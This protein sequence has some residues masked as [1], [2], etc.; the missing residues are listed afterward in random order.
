MDRSTLS[1]S[2]RSGAIAASVALLLACGGSGSGGGGDAGGGG[3]TPAAGTTLAGVVAIGSPIAGAQVQ[4][5]CRNGGTGGTAT[6]DAGGQYQAKLADGCAGPW[7][8]ES[9]GGAP[10]GQHLFSVR[11][12]PSAGED[13]ANLHANI[14]SLTDLM[15][16]YG[17][18]VGDDAATIV[19][20]I[21]QQTEVVDW[22]TRLQ[23]DLQNL[24]ARLDGLRDP[25]MP[26]L[27]LHSVVLVKFLP[28]PG[29]RMD[30]FLERLKA[31]RGNLAI[32]DL[33]EQAEVKGGNPA[34][35]QPWKTVFGER[36][37]I[38]FQGVACTSMGAP[39][40]PASATLRTVGQ[41]LEV[42]LQSDHF[43]SPRT[44]V[45]GP[46]VLSEFRLVVRGDSPYV[47][48][49]AANS[50]SPSVELF[51]V[52]GDPWISISAGGGTSLTCTLATPLRR[53]DLVAFRPAARLTS[54]VPST[55]ASISCA[56]A[57]GH[58]SRSYAVSPLGDVRLDG[59]SLPGNW[60]EEAD[61]YYT[62]VLQYRT[63]RTAVAYQIQLSS[64]S[65]RL[66]LLAFYNNVSGLG[67]FCAD[68]LL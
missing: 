23:A 10:A 52:D 24:I 22:Q 31:A 64:L 49:R 26:P 9:T 61:S 8:L 45:V 25:A 59:A 6:T 12:V 7:V 30:D 44:F 29:D 48:L 3:A 65:T 47:R 53:A 56:P 5:H 62:E 32:A 15:T 68:W 60:A 13:P 11:D 46:A 28:V 66:G 37:S 19:D 57:L 2:L 41:N 40:P 34:S 50:T 55:G 51:T 16:R 14:T 17:F 33:G 35:G 39:A 20:K 21:R 58:P 42:T 36:T 67:T 54:A 63:A 27:D 38:T 18:K 4:I 1:T 43:G